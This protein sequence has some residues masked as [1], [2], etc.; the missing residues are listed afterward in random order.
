MWILHELE[1]SMDR[2]WK[3]RFFSEEKWGF[4]FSTWRIE[5][6]LCPS[7]NGRFWFRTWLFCR[8]CWQRSDE[9]HFTKGYPTG[10]IVSEWPICWESLTRKNQIY[11]KIETKK[12]LLENWNWNGRRWMPAIPKLA[13]RGPSIGLLHIPLSNITYLE[14]LLNL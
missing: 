8:R 5:V 2:K 9:I 7:R 3:P 13:S 14:I 12:P 6:N 4:L 10:C 1:V 11:S